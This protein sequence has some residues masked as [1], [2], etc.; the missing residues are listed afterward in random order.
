MYKSQKLAAR[1]RVPIVS[2]NILVFN[3]S[4]TGDV[5]KDNEIGEQKLKKQKALKVLASGK[6]QGAFCNIVDKLSSLL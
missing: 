6:K 3:K 4:W 5:A 2:F 1:L